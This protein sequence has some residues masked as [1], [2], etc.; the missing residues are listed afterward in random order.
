MK[1]QTL[2]KKQQ[3]NDTLLKEY[4]FAQNAF[5][6]LERNTW[7]TASVFVVLSV[8]GISLLLTLN[9]HTLTSFFMVFGISV[10]S[11]LILWVWLGVTERWWSIQS[12]YLYRMEEIEVELGM[13]KQRYIDYLDTTRI[14]KLSDEQILVGNLKGENDRILNLDKTI[15]RY[16]K[17][18]VRR[19]MRFL[20]SLLV[21]GWL[22]LVIQEA[23]TTLPAAFGF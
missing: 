2:T 14:F 16:S 17:A 22:A 3:N 11:S 5:Y 18:L 20:V 4:E 9:Q 7:Q 13:W 21:I 23:I 1:K 8:G 6:E 10:I 19:R 15:H 12:V